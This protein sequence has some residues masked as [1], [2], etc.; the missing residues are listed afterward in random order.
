MRWHLGIPMA[1]LSCA[2][3]AC[4]RDAETTSPA[5]AAPVAES[6][7]LPSPAAPANLPPAW[8]T[9]DAMTLAVPPDP[10][11]AS[12][13]KA[14]YER[15]DIVLEQVWP[16]GTRE[17]WWYSPDGA[18]RHVGREGQERTGDAR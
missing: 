4:H 8:P 17:S 14:L 1:C 18:V 2:L 16:D 15:G 9:G 7:S 13:T 12:L 11:A 5:A 3:V 6:S 10:G